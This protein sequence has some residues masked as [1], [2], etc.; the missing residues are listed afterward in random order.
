MNNRAIGIMDSG[1]GGLTVAK[2]LHE[3]Y[4]RES[5]VFIGDTARNPYGS[6]TNEEIISFSEEMKAFLYKKQVKMVLVAC[7]TISFTVPE[8]Y[9]EG[10]I[11]VVGM[12]FAVS[13]PKNREKLAILATP[14]TIHTHHHKRVIEERWPRWDMIEVPLPDLAHAIEVGEKREVLRNIATKEI[15]AYGA[16]D[17]DVALLA[18]THYPLMTDILQDIMP[19]TKL[20]DPAEETVKEAMKQ[21][22]EKNQLADV[23]SPHEFFF[24]GG[25]ETSRPLVKQ[26]FGAE[27]S[28]KHIILSGE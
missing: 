22:E 23:S 1:I 20:I 18:C 19:H 8:S 12:S 2:A 14:A 24:T 15:S 25:I 10:D 11:P 26:L 17:A 5:I 6:R 9:Y 13:P 21:L 27:T 16:L 4:P 7:N 3:K 28:V